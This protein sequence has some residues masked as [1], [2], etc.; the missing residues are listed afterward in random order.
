MKQEIDHIHQQ[1]MNVAR[2]DFTQLKKDITVEEA[3]KAIRKE[4][5]GEK[6]VYFYVVD[7]NDVL[8]GVLPTRRLLGAQPDEKLSDIMV[9]NV[10]ALPATSTVLDA[11]ELFV[12][13]KFLAF[14]VVD[15][16]HRIVGIVDVGFF[17]DEVFDIAEKEHLNELFETIGFHV[18]QVRDATTV[19]AFRFRFPWLMATI[20]GGTV[21][22]FLA[23]AFEMTIAR[24]IILAFFLTLVLGLGESVATQSMAVTI[25]KLRHAR[26]TLGWYLRMFVHEIGTALM[27]GAASGFLVAV[28][29]LFWKGALITA[30]SVG[31]SILLAICSACLLGLS[32]PT[33]LHKFDLD[34]KI[35]SGPVTLALADI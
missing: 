24:S 16:K 18:S 17:T 2:K 28:V 22:A 30:F 34:P 23:G 5:L 19:K 9:P 33:L 11:C 20:T 10:V 6:I 35:S 31:V 13:H 4:E 29:I 8:V 1:V 27:L 14:P 32:I 21:A 26:P 3:L 15:E 12:M 25:Q 7:K